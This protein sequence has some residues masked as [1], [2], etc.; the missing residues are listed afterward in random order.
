VVPNAEDGPVEPDKVTAIDFSAATHDPL[1]HYQRA[2][3]PIYK[4]IAYV[5]LRPLLSWKTRKV[6]GPEYLTIP[7]LTGLLTERGYGVE[8]R[9]AWVTKRVSVKG[10]RMLIQGAGTGWDT[11]SWAR[12][13]PDKITGVD[14]FSFER[15][16]KIIQDYANLHDFSVPEFLLGSLEEL[17]IASESIDLI[18]SDAV[19]EHCRDMASVLR[20]TYRVLRP[21]GYVYAGY[22]PMWFSFGGDHF[23]PRAG[24]DHGFAHIE[25]DLAQYKDFFRQHRMASE[26][27]QSGGRYVELDLFSK[28]TTRQYLKLYFEAGFEV[29]DFRLIV[30][31]DAVRFFR[32][33]PD[34]VASMLQIHPYITADDLLINGNIVLLRRTRSA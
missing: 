32:K 3:S 27:A 5:F 21:G 28:L 2:R 30:S 33:W 12:L 11:L 29:V 15:D 9:R 8:T 6:L 31:S 20:E 17:P 34:R 13:R 7:N 24:R 4:R 1:L 26:D 14:L 18:A 25:L 19:W 22:G 23:C 10:C 16:W